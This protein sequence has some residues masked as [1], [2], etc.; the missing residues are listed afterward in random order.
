[1]NY[2]NPIWI[3]PNVVRVI[4][5]ELISIHGGL[6]GIR[7]ESLLESALARPLNLHAYNVNVSIVELAAC[8][9]VGLAKNHP[10]VDGNKRVALT[11]GATFLELNGLS[12]L[13]PEPETVIV[14]NQVADGSMDEQ[15]L[16]KWYDEFSHRGNN[17]ANHRPFTALFLLC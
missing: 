17:A 3:L 2:S 14:F 7:D 12:L 5:Q 10:F 4:H 8:Y 11:V 15:S 13:A 1:M 16:A 6:P 9:S